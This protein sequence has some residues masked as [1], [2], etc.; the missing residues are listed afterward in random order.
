MDILIRERHNKIKTRLY[1]GNRRRERESAKSRGGRPKGRKPTRRRPPTY[2]D[3]N[4][5]KV[6]NRHQK[7]KREKEIL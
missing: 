5:E 2:C 1:S 6:K 7:G 4:R 3:K